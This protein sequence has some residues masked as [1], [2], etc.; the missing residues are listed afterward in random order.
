M[1]KKK[2]LEKEIKK[3]EIIFEKQIAML[4]ELKRSLRDK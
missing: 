3:L 4:E 2:E 1:D